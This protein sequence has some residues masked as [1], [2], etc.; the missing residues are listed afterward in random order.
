MGKPTGGISLLSLPPERAS[1]MHFMILCCPQLDLDI[2][3]AHPLLTHYYPHQRFLASVQ[4]HSPF[5][6]VQTW[7][8]LL[9]P[10]KK[11]Q[12]NY[13]SSYKGFLL[14]D[15]QTACYSQKARLSRLV[16]WLKPSTEFQLP[17]DVQHQTRCFRPGACPF[18]ISSHFPP[19]SPPL[20]IPLQ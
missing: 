20:G 3:C 18:L 16:L 4:I 2:P 1:S 19:H 14:L 13:T 12:L 6:R 5:L 9:D 11:L 8:F 17:R 10:N 7:L 15:T